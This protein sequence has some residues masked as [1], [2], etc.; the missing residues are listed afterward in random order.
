[1]YQNNVDTIRKT[2]HYDITM[3]LYVVLFVYT[4]T[5]YLDFTCKY[6]LL[7]FH[8]KPLCLSQFSIILF[9]NSFLIVKIPCVQHSTITIVFHIETLV[10]YDKTPRFFLSNTLHKTLPFTLPF[11]NSHFNITIKHPSI[12]FYIH[13]QLHTSFIF[14]PICVYTFY[15]H[16]YRNS[17][18]APFY[19]FVYTYS[20]HHVLSSRIHCIHISYH[21]NQTRSFRCYIPR[22][23]SMLFPYPT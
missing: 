2:L 20:L 6:V 14:S 22:F 8:C 19:Q 4:Q 12:Q 10:F 23:E 21:P 13:C 15:T 1:V 18:Y 7:I 16:S 9:T 5:Q 3:F 11:H 17:I